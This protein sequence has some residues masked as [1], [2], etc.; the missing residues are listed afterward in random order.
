MQNICFRAEYTISGC[1]S[2][3]ASILLRWTQN[4]VWECFGAFHKPLAHKRCKLMF[5][6]ECTIL[7]YQC[8]EASILLRYSLGK[9]MTKEYNYVDS[10]L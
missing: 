3:E 6:P 4:D 8:C 1:Q 7:G 2:C 10:C 9:D 5:E